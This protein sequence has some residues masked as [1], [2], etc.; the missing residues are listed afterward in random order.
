MA[1]TKKTDGTDQAPDK[2]K[3]TKRRDK[4]KELPKPS[5]A[6]KGK[7][8]PVFPMFDKENKIFFTKNLSA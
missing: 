7:H 5:P 2:Q 8:A 6:K 1:K 4:E 3:T